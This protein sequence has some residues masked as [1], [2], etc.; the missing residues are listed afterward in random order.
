MRSTR[1]AGNPCQPRLG[2]AAKSL[3]LGEEGSPALC[4]VGPTLPAGTTGG[5]LK[6]WWPFRTAR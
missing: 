6:A 1:N 4:G 3:A 5:P 2:M